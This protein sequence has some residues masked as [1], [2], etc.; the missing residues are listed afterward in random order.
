MFILTGYR[1]VC[2]NRAQYS[3]T[4]TRQNL[5]HQR[6]LCEYLGCCDCR[7]C[8]SKKRPQGKTFSLYSSS[9]I[10]Q[11]VTHSLFWFLTQFGKPYGARYIGSMVADVHRTLKYGG[12]FMYPTSK[13]APNGKVSIYSPSYLI[14]LLNF[15]YTVCF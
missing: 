12:I 9:N 3:N 7:I 2:P 1:R 14:S 11:G 10:D 13:D 15:T 8:C 4:E 5:Q 6:R